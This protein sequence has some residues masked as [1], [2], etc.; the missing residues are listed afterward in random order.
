MP[1]QMSRSVGAAER[2][3][4]GP[5]PDRRAILNASPWS[6]RSTAVNAD[7]IALLNEAAR[8]GGRHLDEIAN[9]YCAS[10]PERQPVARTYLRENLRFALDERAIEGLRTYYREAASL[11]FVTDR[12]LEWF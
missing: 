1:L 9:A 8:E 12:P 10:S 7:T 2:R 11:G 3:P 6:G 4:Q 5:Q